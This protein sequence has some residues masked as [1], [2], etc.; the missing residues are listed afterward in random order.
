VTVSGAGGDSLTRTT[1]QVSQTISI[2]AIGDV[3]RALQRV[4][5]V[6]LADLNPSSARVTV[7]H[8]GAVLKSAL[9]SAAKGAGA[10][11]T[12]V[13]EAKP[14]P[15]AAATS[16]VGALS[17]A[18]EAPRP[19]VRASLIAMSTVAVVLICIDLLVPDSPQKRLVLNALV[20]AVWICFF[21]GLYV[22]R[23]S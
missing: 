17:P 11:A 14:A 1:L 6:L 15:P 3:V 12:I 13:R 4:P 9:V 21:A 2:A 8:D 18:R 20:L 22:R 7:A 16:L 23:K 5:G 10:H 19:H